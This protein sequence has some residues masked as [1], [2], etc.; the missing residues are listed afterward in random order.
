MDGPRM[1][2]AEG[3]RFVIFQN[4]VLLDAT[5]SVLFDQPTTLPCTFDVKDC[6]SGK[7]TQFGVYESQ[8]TVRSF[9]STI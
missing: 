1:F 8:N 3:L 6:D 4:S 9:S 7:L 2:M 5:R